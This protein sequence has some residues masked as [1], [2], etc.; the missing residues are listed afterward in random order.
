MTGKTHRVGGMLCCLAGYSILESKGML[1]DEVSPL[2]QLTVMYP[3]AIYGSIVS[4]LDHNW[5]SAPSK[6]IVSFGINKMLHLTTNVSEGI[7]KKIP[8]LRIFDAKH[9]SWQTHSDLFLVLMLILSSVFINGSVTSADGIILKL[10]FTGLIL[11][12]VSH[13]VLDLLTP[14]GLWSLP[15]SA[16]S[17]TKVTKSFEKIHLVPKTKFFATGGKW[18]DFI[19]GLMWVICLILLLRLVYII[20]PYKISLGL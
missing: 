15:G 20:S 7:K 17:K 11:G 5:H 3:F 10:V 4:D 8:I 6:D 2:L 18:E 19:R 13:L 9:R 12:I 14:E 16:L 1:L